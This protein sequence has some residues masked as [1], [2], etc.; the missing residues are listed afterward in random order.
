MLDF[1]F[2]AEAICSVLGILDRVDV[3]FGLM[4]VN[5]I[6]CGQDEELLMFSFLLRELLLVVSSLGSGA[7]QPLPQVE[8]LLVSRVQVGH[9]ITHV[10]SV[11]VF[12]R[13]TVLSILLLML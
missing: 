2:C 7:F 3:L 8:D 12:A 5:S 11:G 4:R 13:V 9:H 6:F 1:D 10:F